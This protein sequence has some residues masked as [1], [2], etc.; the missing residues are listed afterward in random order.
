MYDQFK[1][2]YFTIFL[3]RQ[4][5]YA[6]TS[7]RGPF[8]NMITSLVAGVK[9]AD[10]SPPY[11]TEMCSVSEAGSYIRLEDVCITQF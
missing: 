7:V 11:F 8:L 9:V 4:F 1:H 6:L 10:G 3:W 2:N 5:L